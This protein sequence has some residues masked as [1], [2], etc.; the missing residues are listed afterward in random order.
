MQIRILA[1]TLLAASLSTGTTIWA[2][3]AETTAQ[4][5]A[6]AADTPVQVDPATMET[7]NISKVAPIYPMEA[8]NAAI[9]GD[10]VLYAI[11]DEKGKVKSLDVLSGTEILR[12]PALAAVNQWK[13]APYLV[14]E[15]PVK[16]GTIITIHFRL[17][18]NE[19]TS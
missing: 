14:D 16:V 12:K 11:V 2:Q 5:N 17:S 1:V 6:Q 4:V 9:E 7:M 3:S 10:V 15:V 19:S 8:K 13:Y 18:G